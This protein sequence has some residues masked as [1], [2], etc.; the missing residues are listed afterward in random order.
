MM[1][2]QV[3]ID[4][5]YMGVEGKAHLAFTRKTCRCFSGSAV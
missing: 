1:S 5:V 3:V 2:T 4:D